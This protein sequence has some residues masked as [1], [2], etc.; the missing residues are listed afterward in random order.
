MIEEFGE[1]EPLLMVY[2]VCN[3]SGSSTQVK[4]ESVK[5][6]FDGKL[7][8]NFKKA[9]IFP[10]IFF[11]NISPIYSFIGF[12]VNIMLYMVGKMIK[13]WLKFRDSL[14]RLAYSFS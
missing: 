4:T 9:S 8:H 10:Q 11:V 13:I 6:T 5:N 3:T 7:K 12:I 1:F 2:I 14:P